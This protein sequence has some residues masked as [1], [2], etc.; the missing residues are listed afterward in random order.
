METQA[1]SPTELPDE[2]RRGDVSDPITQD[3]NAE[4]TQPHSSSAGPD[5]RTNETTLSNSKES[6]PDEELSTDT[7]TI[8]N[9]GEI[10]PGIP[11]VL[12]ETA[13][14]AGPD[15]P[16]VIS[17]EYPSCPRGSHPMVCCVKTKFETTG[18]QQ[19]NLQQRR[20]GAFPQDIQENPD[21]NEPDRLELLSI[22]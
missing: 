10:Y 5:T 4:N 11:R 8:D 14:E 17:K 19:N 16:K 9:Q 15:H 22:D 13:P 7:P 3:G 6:S 18:T 21:K 12:P 20:D 1:H 2:T